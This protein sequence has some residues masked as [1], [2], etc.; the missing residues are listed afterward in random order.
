MKQILDD[1]EDQTPLRQRRFSRLSLG[2]AFLT[3]VLLGQL[4]AFV[5]SYISAADQVN[6][7]PPKELMW[8]I[9][10]TSLLGMTFT[11]LSFYQK[12]E[13]TVAKWLGG[14]LNVLLFLLLIGSFLSA[15]FA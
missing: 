12:E 2:F 10:L 3:I 5:K 15:K 9:V 1:I 4:N 14:M 13:I 7:R 6:D 11:V 8:G